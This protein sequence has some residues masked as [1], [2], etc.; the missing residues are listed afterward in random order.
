MIKVMDRLERFYGPLPQPPGEPFAL[1]AWEVLGVH[2][3]AARRDAAMSALRRIPALTPDSMGRAPRAT[4]ESAVALSG[5]YREE[6]LRALVAGVDVF[7]RHR[8]LADRLRGDATAAIGALA[9][10]PYLTT[11]S[12]Q[13]LLLFAGH[14]PLLPDDPHLQ[15]VLARL[16]TASEAVSRELGDVLT[17]IQRATLYLSHHGRS[18]CLESNPLCHVCPLRSE[19]P[20]PSGVAA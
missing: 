17:A 10:L 7:K 8:D 9:L 13:R 18:T 1:Y 3:T 5:P 15:R 6:R 19:C 20:F 11:I 16:Q 4:L 14:H 2:T 12:G